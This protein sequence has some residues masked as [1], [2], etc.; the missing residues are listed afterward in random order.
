VIIA[1][2]MTIVVIL[3]L[4]ETLGLSSAKQMLTFLID[5]ELLTRI[6]DFRYANRFP[7]RAGAIRWLLQWALSRAPSPGKTR[8][9]R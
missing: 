5:V 9:S 4:G 3:I 8:R 6:D 1:F 2:N 7:T